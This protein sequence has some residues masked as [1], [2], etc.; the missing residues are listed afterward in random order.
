MRALLPYLFIC[1]L[2]SPQYAALI[3]TEEGQVR[4]QIVRLEEKE[5]TLRLESGTVQTINKD[6]ILTIHDDDGKLIWSHPSIVV[7]DT[8][9][10]KP[11]ET[12][13]L[14]LTPQR[15]PNWE[16]EAT[17]G[18]G[19]M[20]STAWFSTYP[21]GVKHDYRML[22]E[23]N[24][25]G[26][27]NLDGSSY[28]TASLGYSQRDM[29]ANGVTM[30]GLYGVAIWPMRFIDARV[31]YRIREEWLFVEAGLL[32]TFQVGAS[33]V[34]IDGG[35]RSTTFSDA[36]AST[37]G[38]LGFYVAL[39]II[40]QVYRDLEGLFMLRYDHGLSS[41]VDAKIATQTAP[42]GTVV[43]SAPLHLVPWSVSAHVGLRYPLGF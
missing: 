10:D 42:D 19:L 8:S 34:T 21:L 20:S 3:V 43:S 6:K 28:L 36:R 25:T 37:G 15:R 5:V 2:A 13:K 9:P 24:L 11:G 23:F 30:E 12:A 16:I 27:Y 39:G 40:A 17:F 41:A 35:S 38:Y 18:L 26:L 14:N 29:T 32:Q 1:L 31:G 7:N 33:P 4:G 22:T